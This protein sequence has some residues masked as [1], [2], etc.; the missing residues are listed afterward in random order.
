MPVTGPQVSAEQLSRAVHLRPSDVGHQARW[1]AERQLDEPGRDLAGVD[2]LEPET[3]RERY[4]RQPGHL[5]R[6]H[7]D[8]VV[9]LGGA[10][11]RP[12]QAGI[13]HDAL[14]RELGR[15]VA[16]HGAVDAADDRDPVG[17]DD[18]DVHQVPR[19][20]P[21][22][23]PDQ[24]PG[25]LLVALAAARA[26][27]DDLDSLHR[28]LDPLARGQVTG[29][30]LDT[31]LGLAAVPAEH[32]Y[33]AARRPAAAG[34]RGVRACPC[35]LLPEYV[36]FYFLSRFSVLCMPLSQRLVQETRERG[37]M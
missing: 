23:C 1:R 28:G 32:A 27:H 4:H 14:G 36:A 35:R 7:Q 25:L 2:R 19:P 33:R 9:E 6:Y 18:R 17:A 13:G 31:L 12:G 22:R 29:H 11:R 15:E 8:Q 34:R 16:E 5:L 30:E 26:V 37:Q 3:G 24:V 10:Q 21:R 20:G